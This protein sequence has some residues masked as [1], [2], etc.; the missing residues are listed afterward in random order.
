MCDGFDV[1]MVVLVMLCDGLVGVCEVLFGL[2]VCY[3]C[4]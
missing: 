1:V 4:V 3:V 2:D